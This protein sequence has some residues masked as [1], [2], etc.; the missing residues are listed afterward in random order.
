MEKEYENELLHKGPCDSCGSSDA[1]ANYSDGQSHCYSCGKH[2]N[3]DRNRDKVRNKKPKG[4]MSKQKSELI[5]GES[6]F[7]N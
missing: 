6:V 5:T 1:C 3:S 7:C 4:N 2:T